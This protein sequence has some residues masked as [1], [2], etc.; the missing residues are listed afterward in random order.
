MNK[1]IQKIQDK[2]QEAKLIRAQ[3]K[4]YYD[5]SVTILE[6]HRKNIESL[7]ERTLEANDAYKD[8]DKLV[9]QYELELKDA[10]DKYELKENES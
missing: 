4:A 7:E 9:S 1:E 6:G 8:S 10:I 2:M 5:V 3:K